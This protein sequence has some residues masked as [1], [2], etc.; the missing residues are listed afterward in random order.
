MS[1]IKIAKPE[2][3]QLLNLAT[4]EDLNAK[5]T[6][7]ADSLQQQKKKVPD[8]LANPEKYDTLTQK[9]LGLLRDFLK[10]LE[11]LALLASED[12]QSEPTVNESELDVNEFNVDSQPITEDVTD[13]GGDLA[14]PSDV[15]PSSLDTPPNDSN[16]TPSTNFIPQV[17][18]G[19]KDTLIAGTQQ[20]NTLAGVELSDAAF[21]ALKTGFLARTEAHLNA[22]FAGLEVELEQSLNRI[23]ANQKA[24]QQSESSSLGK[25]HTKTQEQLTKMTSLFAQ[26]DISKV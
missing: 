8:E 21:S 13:V 16:I 6:E 18:M 10:P 15:P 25:L 12:V 26:L 1:T 19:V 4:I 11:N 2:V 24:Q 20:V 23:R 17:S 5:I 22:T 9:S 7:L 3:L 14:P